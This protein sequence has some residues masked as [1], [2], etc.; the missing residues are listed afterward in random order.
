MKTILVTGGGGFIGSNLVAGLLA[1]GTHHVVVCDAFGSD[2]KWRNLSKHVVF[3]II[4]PEQM[5]E[6]LEINRQEIDLVYHLAAI[7][8]T[9]EQDIDLLLKH[10]F[11]LSLKLWRWCTVRG[12][13]L[14]YA[15]SSPT[16][17]DGGQGFDDDISL[18]YMQTLRPMSGY[19][20]CKHLFDMYVAGAFARG[21]CSLPQWVGLKFFNTYGPNEYH[22]NG[23]KSVISKIAPQAMQ[24]AAVKLFKS[25]HED[26]PDGGQKRDMIYVKD[27]VKVMLWLLD[28][29]TV[30]GL[31][32]LGTGKAST[33][34]DMAAAIFAAIGCEP[35]IHYIDMP[36]ELVKNYQYAT[37]AKM[38]RLRAAGYAEPF[39]PLAAGIKDYVQNYLRKDDPYL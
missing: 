37:E 36:E 32:N 19:G 2:D 7:S 21:E 4:T 23:Q 8:S 12:V 27:A 22:K 35:N 14:I 24:G 30:S 3:E 5:F 18:A 11:S 17:G 34:N 1:R 28:H 13:R 9:I 39:T 33:F 20:W 29:P 31:F 38:G 15:S 10:N 25:Y 6:W 16:Y 26:Y